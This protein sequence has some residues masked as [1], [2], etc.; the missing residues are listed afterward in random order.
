MSAPGL[1]TTM[2]AISKGQTTGVTRI[3]TMDLPHEGSSSREILSTPSTV[4]KMAGPFIQPSKHCIP[5]EILSHLLAL[6]GDN[7]TTDPRHLL[8]N[9]SCKYTNKTAVTFDDD[10]KSHIHFSGEY[11]DYLL[12][13]G[14]VVRENPDHA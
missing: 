12:L 14:T 4:Y 11:P 6:Y 8:G 13:S 1:D 9:F 3:L 7:L 2:I 10:L 5:H